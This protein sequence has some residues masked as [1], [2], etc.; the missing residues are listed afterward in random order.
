VVP[1]GWMECAAVG[2]PVQTRGFGAG[3]LPMKVPLSE[4]FSD[5]KL[6][7]TPVS[8]DHMHT[9][10]EFLKKSLELHKR[11]VGMVVDLTFTHKYY[12]GKKAFESEG[13]EYL[14]IMT[15]GGGTEA[16]KKADLDNFA[17]KVTDFFQ[18]R[19]EDFCAVH[20][21][22][23]INRSGFFIVTFLI[24]HCNLACKDAL[25][26]FAASRA[27]GI[28]DHSYIDELYLRHGGGMKPGPEAYPAIPPCS[29][30]KRRRGIYM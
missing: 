18:R 17:K 22:H 24:E 15:Q 1:S 25:A 9:P 27:P 28:W 19:P 12:D 29:K 4:E 23:G 14:K 8:A 10:Q 21:T 6:C 13:V 20:C 7:Q 3:F 5:E 26:A 30:E 16:P 11:K 2:D